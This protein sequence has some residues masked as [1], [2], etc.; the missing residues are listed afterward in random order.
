VNEVEKQ[1][2]LTDRQQ[3]IFKMF[4][5]Q[6]KNINYIADI[7]CVSPMVINNELKI[8]RMKLAKVLT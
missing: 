5:L 3:E 6:K 8:I 1:L 2:I 7:L 4:Y